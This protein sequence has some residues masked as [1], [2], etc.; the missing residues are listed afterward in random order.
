M[1]KK[2]VLPICKLCE[3]EKEITFHGEYMQYPIFSCPIHGP[4][5]RNEW[6]IWL[7]KYKDSWKDEC[8]WEK[9]NSK[10]SCIVGFF[11]N[12]FKEH[13]GHPYIFN[14]ANPIPYKDKDFI[15]AR[16]I[17]TMFNQ[18]AKEVRVYIKWVFEKRIKKTNYRV[19]SI[20]FFASSNLVNEYF[21]AKAK[22]KILKRFN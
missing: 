21:Q 10:I 13:Y 19:T 2:K 22:S 18:D 7:D 15:M 8:E 11:C 6:E 12:Y 16:R 5:E 4:D 9:S 14:Y 1:S 3:K 20:G 17:L